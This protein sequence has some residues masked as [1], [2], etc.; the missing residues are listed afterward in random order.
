MKRSEILEYATVLLLVLM[1]GF[2]ILVSYT[3][4]L[5]IAPPQEIYQ[6]QQIE[7]EERHG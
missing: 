5:V 3:A 7:K 4:E 2:I 1:I 6:E